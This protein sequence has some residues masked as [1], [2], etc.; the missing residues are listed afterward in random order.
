MF[1][2]KEDTKQSDPGPVVIG[3][4]DSVTAHRRQG[5]REGGEREREGRWDNR[6]EAAEE[7]E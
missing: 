2:H 4:M 7:R 6:G 3:A 5:E 1:N